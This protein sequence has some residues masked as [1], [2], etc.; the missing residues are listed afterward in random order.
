MNLE[1][2]SV[3]DWLFW[4]VEAT[5]VLKL[6]VERTFELLAFRS[7]GVGMMTYAEMEKG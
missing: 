1:E 7:K 6:L 2:A 5:S 3:V 4:S